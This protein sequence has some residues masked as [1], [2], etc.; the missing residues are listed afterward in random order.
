[1][2]KQRQRAKRCT[3]YCPV[4][5]AA[6]DYDYV[7]QPISGSTG[8]P[9]G[10]Y[11]SP[12]L[13]LNSASLS[14]PIR[15]FQISYANV[16]VWELSSTNTFIDGQIVNSATGIMPESGAAY[17]RNLLFANVSAVFG[18]QIIGTPA[19]SIIDS[20]NVNTTGRK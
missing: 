7:G 3:N 2:G 17:L 12:A 5:F 6:M 19:F 15:H 1:M 13:E 20:Q 10:Y 14:Q 8:V 11:A 9:S 16:G 18:S 4:V